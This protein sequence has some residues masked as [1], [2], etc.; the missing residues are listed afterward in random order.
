VALAAGC[1][2]L[3]LFYLI[4]GPNGGE[5]IVEGVL[6]WSMV[7]VWKISHA[8][9]MP[10]THVSLYFPP[11]ILLWDPLVDRRYL[12]KPTP[13]E[14]FREPALQASAGNAIQF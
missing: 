3:F 8:E 10:I 4:L 7:R 9:H 5:M 2:G 12:N 14:A 11:R 6:T 1:S 13:S